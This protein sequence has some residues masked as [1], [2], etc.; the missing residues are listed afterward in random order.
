MTSVQPG[1]ELRDSEL[2]AIYRSADQVSV[3]GQ[4]IT[5]RL[6]KTELIIEH[7]PDDEWAA[8]AEEAEDAI[9][10]EHTLWAARRGY[11]KPPS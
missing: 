6:V 1:V 4:R 7:V 11:S 3:A 10:R 9:S 8:F 5:K 2:S